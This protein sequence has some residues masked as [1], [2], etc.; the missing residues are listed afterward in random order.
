[1]AQ[2]QDVG[3]QKQHCP[4]FPLRQGLSHTHGMGP[5]QV[6]MESSDILV[7]QSH[8]RQASQPCGQAIYGLAGRD[9]PLDHPPRPAHTLRG[10]AGQRGLLTASDGDNVIDRESFPHLHRHADPEG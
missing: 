10:S 5:E 9:L 1:M 7:G 3:T 8:V 6:V 2:R 4:D